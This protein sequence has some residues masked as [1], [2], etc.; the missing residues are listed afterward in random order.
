MKTFGLFS[1]FLLFA[2]YAKAQLPV[3]DIAAN[4]T[5]QQNLEIQMALKALSKIAAKVASKTQGSAAMTASLVGSSVDM[6]SSAYST[7]ISQGQSKDAGAGA[8]G[9]SLATTPQSVEF[10]KK[11]ITLGKYIASIGTLI[12][13][14]GKYS[15]PTKMAFYQSSLTNALHL[16]KFSVDKSATANDSNLKISMKER[17]DIVEESNG[18]L[19]KTN[20][21][22]SSVSKSLGADR[23]EYQNEDFRNKA[24]RALYP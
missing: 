3:T 10:Y 1:I 21:I 2:F 24:Y 4:T 22:L 8:A 18:T 11:T 7:N 20:S 13:Q 12:G 14:Y 19:D 5:N 23:V 17:V 9:S 15:S 6:A 16:F